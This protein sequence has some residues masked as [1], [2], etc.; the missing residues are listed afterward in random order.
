MHIKTLNNLKLF[1]SIYET[2]PVKVAI[3]NIFVYFD[4]ISSWF[5]HDLYSSS[6][7]IDCALVTC[8]KVFIIILFDLQ[9]KHVNFHFSALKFSNGKSM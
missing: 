2:V 8:S 5:K 4:S 9:C 3:L 6:V 7:E 1:N